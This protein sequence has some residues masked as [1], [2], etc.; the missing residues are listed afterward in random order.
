MFRLDNLASPDEVFDSVGCIEAL[1][2]NGLRYLNP[3]SEW[4][5]QTVQIFP[6][7]PLTNNFL[8]LSF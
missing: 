8:N 6:V 5:I 1:K 7:S 2:K 3:Q 4:K